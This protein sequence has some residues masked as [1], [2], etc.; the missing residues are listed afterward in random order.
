VLEARQLSLAYGPRLVVRD[1]ELAIG[2]AAVTALIGANGSGKSTILRALSRLLSPL[3]G[4]VLLDGK[5]IHQQPTR[6]IAKRLAFLPQRGESPEGLTVY[7]LVANG[8]FPH[9]SAL[10]GLGA[11]DRDAIE[12]A[13][14]TVALEALSDRPIDLLSGGERQ[15][16]FIAMALAQETEYLLLDEP[17]TF[18]DLRHQLEVLDLVR[19]L[20][21]D[22]GKTVVMVLHDLNLAARYA[23]RIVAVRG[24]NIVAAGVPDAVVH[25]E[26]LKEVFG[27]TAT[28]IRDPRYGT[29][30]CLAYSAH[31]D[32]G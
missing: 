8:R 16:A 28:V 15:R 3:H 14:R 13:I 12:R 1:L 19:G 31:S 22:A 11:S 25:P 24:G 29:P 20:H 30:H 32:D 26:V 9:R 6:E 10:G 18:L 17:T 7:E 23:D 5:A 21:R 4:A 27:V 2:R